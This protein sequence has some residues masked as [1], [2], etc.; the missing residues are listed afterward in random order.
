MAVKAAEA[1]VRMEGDADARAL[2]DLADTYFVAGDKARAR[3][4][5]RKAAEAAVGESAALRRYIDQQM[6]M[7]GDDKK[8]DKE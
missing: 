1:R 6:R 7:F 8:Q 3:E 4:F 5:A 2:I